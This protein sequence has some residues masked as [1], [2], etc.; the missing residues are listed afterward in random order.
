MT[1][2]AVL[3]RA[4]ETE[5]LVPPAAPAAARAGRRK[6]GLGFFFQQ[7]VY[8]FHCLSSSSRYFLSLLSADLYLWLTVLT[9]IPLIFATSRRL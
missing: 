5:E 7:L 6:H 4:G 9:G 8:A 1:T 2:I 3:R